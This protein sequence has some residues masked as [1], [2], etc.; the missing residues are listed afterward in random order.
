ME[1]DPLKIPAFM[2]QHRAPAKKSEVMLVREAKIKL[3]AKPAIRI[4]IPQPSY[5]R[6][7]TTIFVDPLFDVPMPVKQAKI[8]PQK[9]APA[10]DLYYLSKYQKEGCIYVR[11]QMLGTRD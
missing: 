3:V 5:R 4:S 2:R 11:Y 8:K 7:T 1:I 10:S 6:P 9:W